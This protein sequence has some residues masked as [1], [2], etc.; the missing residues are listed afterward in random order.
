[1]A[2]KGTTH[3]VIAPNPKHRPSKHPFLTNLHTTMPD[4]RA[5]LDMALPLVKSVSDCADWS[6]TV[7][8][9]LPQLYDL[10]SQVAAHITDPQ[11]LQHIYATTNPLITALGF[12]VFFMTPLV[13]AVAE[14][15][16][17]YS[18]VDRLWSVLPVLY[19]VHYN[20][21]AHLN[22]LP[23][24]RLNHIMAVSIIWGTR[25]SFNYWRKG[26][27][28]VGS[29]DYRWAIV[30]DYAGPVGMFLFD[31]TFIAFAQNVC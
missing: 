18:Q 6:K 4:P 24:F 26:G 31:V 12:A 30:K 7:A 22:D 19:N 21:W 11:A 3:E 5:Y 16:K 2:G 17:N 8:P 15:N 20:V 29:E 10:P 28:S 1:M 13:L 27:Y 9:F 25:L 23:T 14:F